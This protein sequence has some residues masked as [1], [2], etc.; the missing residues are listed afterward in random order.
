MHKIIS[1]GALVLVLCF[2]PIR[3]FPQILSQIFFANT[4]VT[5]PPSSGMLLWWEAD[6]GAN[7]AGACSDGSSQSS[8]ADQSGNGNNGTLTPS[9]SSP[10][11]PSVYHTNQINGKPAVTFNGNTTVGLETCFS[12]GVAGAGLDNKSATSMFLVVK[13]TDNA[14]NYTYASGGSGAYAWDN[15]SGSNLNRSTKACI[16]LIGTGS[17]SDD[18]SW[19]QLNTTYNGSAWTFRKDRATDGSGTNA[20]TIGANWLTLGVNL[21]GGGIAALKGQIAEFILYNRVLSG[22]EITTVETYLNS[23]YGL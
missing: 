3:S 22:P 7:C 15:N 20:Q 12:V 18:T 13:Q 9:I 2:A 19:H 5:P 23:K 21:C 17:A 8:W 10:C 6:V 16:A 11:V 14:G 4:T 1:I